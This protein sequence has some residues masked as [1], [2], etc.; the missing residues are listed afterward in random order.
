MARR[1]GGS[2]A[3]SSSV[4]Q[5]RS[6]SGLGIRR[7][8]LIDP[9][10]SWELLAIGVVT[11]GVTF[12]GGS[13]VLRWKFGLAVLRGFAAGTIVGVALFDLF[14]E[15]LALAEKNLGSVS[16]AVPAA[17]G[18]SFYLGLDR[19]TGA[20]GK[21]KMWANVAPA[22]LVLHSFFDGLGIGFG[23]HVS[24]STGVVI[25]IGVLAHDLIDGVNTV[26][27]AL[28]SGAKTAAARRWLTADTVAPTLGILLATIIAVQAS[29]LALIFSLFGGSLLYVGIE[30]L[31]SQ[32]RL[33]RSNSSM[34]ASAAIG[35]LFIYAVMHATVGW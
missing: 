24:W 14:P 13:L 10:P 30:L 1:S 18:F 9:I 29:A 34:H 3:V 8:R 4:S 16:V 19:V 20:F 27:V 21:R 35:L 22:P 2:D 15:A 11:G 12:V 26:T 32:T 7:T 17:F 6:K 33:E 31:F 5:S 23:F 25:A 28:A